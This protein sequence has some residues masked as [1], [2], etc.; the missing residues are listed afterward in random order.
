MLCLKVKSVSTDLPLLTDR[1]TD[2]DK[3]DAQWNID[4][5][6]ELYVYVENDA[7]VEPPQKQMRIQSDYGDE[8]SDE[9]EEDIC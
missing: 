3:L 9:S 8:M 1:R 7:K 6:V 4:D 5:I 2:R